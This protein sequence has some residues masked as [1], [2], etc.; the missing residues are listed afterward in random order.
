MKISIY[1][2]YKIVGS[3]SA[4]FIMILFIIICIYIHVIIAIIISMI[5]GIA[6]SIYLH[7][8]KCPNCGNSI[9]NRTALFCFNNEEIIKHVSQ[10]CKICGYDLTKKE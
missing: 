2:K 8:I 9:D 4:L 1:R 6:R 5:L 3:V 7:S 10:Q